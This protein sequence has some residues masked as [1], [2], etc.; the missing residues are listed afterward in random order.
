M[1]IYSGIYGNPP[2]LKRYFQQL[3]VFLLALFSMKVTVLFLLSHFDFLFTLGS[4]LLYPVL[5]F[6]SP[7]LEVVVV[8]LI[9][10]LIM[11][12][13]QFWCVDAV[14]KAGGHLDKAKKKSVGLLLSD[15][16]SSPVLP[17]YHQNLERH[18]H[19][20]DDLSSSDLRNNNNSSSSHSPQY[21]NS[22]LNEP[23]INHSPRPRNSLPKGNKVH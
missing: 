3:A 14:I 6:K 19:H 1:K 12:V 2:N 11:N 13:L 23:L 16:E 18:H 15:D 17:R 20:H 21:W 5:M 9:F 4:L 8:M 10:P 22:T 7:R